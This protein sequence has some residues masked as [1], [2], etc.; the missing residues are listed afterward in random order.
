MA[1]YRKGWLKRSVLKAQSLATFFK[2]LPTDFQPSIDASYIE[3]EDVGNYDHRTLFFTVFSYNRRLHKRTVTGRAVISF[4]LFLEFARAL[5]KYNPTI[6]LDKELALLQE[7]SGSSRRLLIYQQGSG[8][9]LVSQWTRHGVWEKWGTVYFTKEQIP[10]LKTFI[11]DFG[12]RHQ[13][14]IIDSIQ[15][16]KRKESSWETTPAR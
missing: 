9:M 11:R 10:A 12:I 16:R 13:K 3:Y 2:K 8:L 7:F 1:Y 6:K 15:R 14:E 4:A 5:Q